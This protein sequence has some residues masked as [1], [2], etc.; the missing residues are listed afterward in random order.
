MKGKPH[1]S[2]TGGQGAREPGTRE[3]KVRGLGVGGILR[4]TA[5]V[6]VAGAVVFAVIELR[7]LVGGLRSLREG[8]SEIFHPRPRTASQQLLLHARDILEFSTIEYIHKSVFPYDFFP[9]ELDW[10]ALIERRR[11]GVQLSDAE[12]DYLT[13]Y[14]LSREVGIPLDREPNRFVVLTVVVKAGYDLRS[15]AGRRADEIALGRLE[16]LHFRGSGVEVSL[17]R[18][19]ITELIVQDA[20]S[21]AYGYPSLDVSPEQWRRIV[22][23]TA[24][25]TREQIEASSILD[26]AA[27]NAQD[28][29]RIFFRQ[30]GFQ[31]VRFE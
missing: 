16:W 21:T 2:G 24:R 18:P 23:F 3:R 12:W 1:E 7:P 30:A 25:K 29:L 6:L 19:A 28:Y 14:E 13:L 17:P 5:A 4:A 9:P 15:L 31:N 26:E 27:T 20:P 8:I 10:A 22:A 11:S